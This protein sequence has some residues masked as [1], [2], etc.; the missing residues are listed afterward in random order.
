[1]DEVALYASDDGTGS[2][3]E[4]IARE[5]EHFGFT[6]FGMEISPFERDEGADLLKIDI[7]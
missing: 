3:E 7:A 4:H 1:M 5:L 6:G 2:F